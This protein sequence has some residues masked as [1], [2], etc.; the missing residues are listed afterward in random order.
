MRNLNEL[1]V[2][3]SKHLDLVNSIIEQRKFAMAGDFARKLV[4]WNE[5]GIYLDFD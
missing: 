4:L 5:G 3:E 1:D 2:V